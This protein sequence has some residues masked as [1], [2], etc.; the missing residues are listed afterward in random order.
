MCTGNDIIFELGM[1]I[2]VVRPN[3]LLYVSL[4]TN[5]FPISLADL[6]DPCE[7]IIHC[8]IF[9]VFSIF[10]IYA[11]LK[12]I[13][14]TNFQIYDSKMAQ[15]VQMVWKNCGVIPTLF[16]WVFNVPSLHALVFIHKTC[17]VILVH[18]HSY[19]KKED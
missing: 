7:I 19:Q 2:I 12:N 14:M 18:V 6:S 16:G 3:T 1:N 9:V 13:F 4:A 10:V 8:K 11:N 15:D 17:E 5:R